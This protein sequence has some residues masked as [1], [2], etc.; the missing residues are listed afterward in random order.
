[1]KCFV[2]GGA[3]VIGRE[4]VSRLIVKGHEIVVGDLQERP[5]EFPA[6]VEYLHGD[7]NHIFSEV[8]CDVFYHLAATFDRLAE[9]P[10]HWEENYRHNVGLSH[11]LLNVIKAKRIVFASSYLVAPHPRNLT[12]AAKLYTECEL[13]FMSKHQGQD[14]ISARIYRSYG[15]G[16]RDV[17]SRWVRAAL[18]GEGI[19]VYNEQ[20]SL[21]FVYAGDVAEAL[22]RMGESRGTGVIPVGTGS[23]RMILDVVTLL[24][25]AFPKLTV[26]WM[27]DQHPLESTS[28][29]IDAMQRHLHWYP[30]TTLEAGIA[31]VIEYE[32]SRCG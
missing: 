1:M 27:P 28:C 7:L 13:E 15:C 32:Q 31:K 17:I 30:F 20:T 16:S 14:C 18:K 12:G 4:L 21:D 8:T 9:G 19:T 24:R 3:G 11:H 2:S 29:N 25:M 26:A 22:M 23:P 10:N 5:Q 6:S